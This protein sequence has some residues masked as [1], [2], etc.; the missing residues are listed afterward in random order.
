MTSL[1]TQN[2]TSDAVE[3]LQALSQRAADLAGTLPQL[4]LPPEEL[5]A[6]AAEL[7]RVAVK[8]SLIEERLAQMGPEVVECN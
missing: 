4:D 8:L 1:D 3:L 2:M 6:V 7:Q 5:E